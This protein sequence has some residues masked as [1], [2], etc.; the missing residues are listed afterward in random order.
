MIYHLSDRDYAHFALPHIDLDA[1]LRA[2]RSL[3]SRNRTADEA[4]TK[5]I[6]ELGDRARTAT[7]ANSW[8]LVDD[9]VDLMHGSVYHDAA[10]SMAAV[11]MLAPMIES[12]FVGTFKAIGR[13]GWPLNGDKRLKRAGAD[14]ERFWDPQVYF[15]KGK[16]KPRTDL[17]LGIDQLLDATGMTGFM[18]EDYQAVIKALFAYRNRMLHS[19]F[20]WPRA[21]RREFADFIAQEGWP[22]AWFSQAT[23]GG[24]PW[25]FYMSE[26]LIERCFAVLDAAL[27]SAGRYIR[28]QSDGTG[29]IDEPPE[30]EPDEQEGTA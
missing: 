17:V 9:H 4:L 1:Q 23:S 25:V 15:P 18:P 29:W 30:P 27:D 3:L 13:Q 20:E 5:E 14:H 11:G 21:A 16:A 8:R 28:E 10:N 22:E 2:I 19:G 12:V 26:A 24:K 7:G 6:Q